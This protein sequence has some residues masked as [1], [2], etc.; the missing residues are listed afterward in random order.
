MIDA[1]YFSDIITMSTVTMAH[2]LKQIPEFKTNTTKTVAV[3]NTAVF[4]LCRTVH[5]YE[6]HIIDT[7]GDSSS[8]VV[9][10]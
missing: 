8:R 9:G 3:C 6:G 2:F 10:A 4:V 7:L 5:H 1:C